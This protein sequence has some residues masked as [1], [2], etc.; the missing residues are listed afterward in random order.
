MFISALQRHTSKPQV[1]HVRRLNELLTWTQIN[2]KNLCPR[3]LAEVTSTRKPSHMQLLMK[4]QKV[5]LILVKLASLGVQADLVNIVARTCSGN[6][7]DYLRR[8]QKHVTRNAFSADLF[9]AGE[10]FGQGEF[11]GHML[12]DVERG[13]MPTVQARYKRSRG[14][15]AQTALYIARSGYAAVTPASIELPT[16][17]DY[18]LTCF[19]FGSCLT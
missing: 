11:V 3:E 8:S 17:K 9:S 18:C 5:D 14:G 10:T 15:F 16:E 4:K 2:P 7:V 6:L 19:I 12:Q 1:K 13:V